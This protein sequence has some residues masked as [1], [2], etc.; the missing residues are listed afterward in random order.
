MKEVKVKA[1]ERSWDI[2]S[3][4]QLHVCAR[5]CVLWVVSPL[6]NHDSASLHSWNPV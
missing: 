2:L 5:A 4:K 6:E 3:I 1:F